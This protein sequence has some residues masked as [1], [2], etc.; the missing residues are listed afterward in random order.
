MVRCRHT[1]P[2]MMMNIDH[3]FTLSATKN[4]YTRQPDKRKPLFARAFMHNKSTLRSVG[5]R[6]MDCIHNSWGQ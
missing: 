1:S 4:N 3:L 2:D 5:R 6:L